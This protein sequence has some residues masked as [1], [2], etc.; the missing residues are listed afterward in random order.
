VIASG[1]HSF[2]PRFPQLS[3]TG[4][5]GI[6]FLCL[7]IVLAVKALPVGATLEPKIVQQPEFSVIGIQAR[8][9]NAREVRGGGVIPKQWTRFFDEG[10]ADKIP[11]KVGSTIYAVYT[12]YASDYNGEYDF[13]IGMKV[14]NVSDVP[15]GMVAKKVP[16]GK[17]AVITSAKGPVAQVVPQAWQ[18]VYSLD[19]NQQ[20]GG[21]RAY[22]ADFELY[23][24]RSQNPQASQVDLY[25]GLK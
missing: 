1:K 4:V 12:N 19:N 3:L 13:I 14:S 23:D 18:R 6:S 7:A 8:T 16:G 22:K 21:P 20:L 15:P 10:I 5:I 11:N 24:Q 2:G 9:S 17:F 25:V